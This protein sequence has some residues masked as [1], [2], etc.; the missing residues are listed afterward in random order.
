L[1]TL[2]TAGRVFHGSPEAHNKAGAGA[3]VNPVGG[4]Q[5]V[6]AGRVRA[7]IPTY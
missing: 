1:T 7:G 3:V 6:P 4:T 5:D 2:C